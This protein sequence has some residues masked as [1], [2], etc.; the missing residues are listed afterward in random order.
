MSHNT[1]VENQTMDF[2]VGI[3]D[4]DGK[5]A[6]A[7]TGDIQRAYSEGTGHSHTFQ[8]VSISMRSFLANNPNID[9]TSIVQVRIKPTIRQSQD[10]VIDNIR[11]EG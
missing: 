2:F 8:T 6:W 3:K 11:L 10:F 1:N 5:L 7:R 9:L 4:Q